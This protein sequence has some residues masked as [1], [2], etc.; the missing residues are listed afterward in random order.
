MLVSGAPLNLPN[1]IAFDAK[2]NIVVVN[3]G[4]RRRD[5][6]RAGR[7]LLD[8]ERPLMPATMGPGHARRWHQ[9]REQRAPGGRCRGFVPGRRRRSVTSGIPSAA[10]M[11][12][13]LEAQ[14]ASVMR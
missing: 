1:G 13:R 9:V 7:E 2:G 14:P 3:I 5:A 11:I 4:T 12:V 10:S 8:A 6:V